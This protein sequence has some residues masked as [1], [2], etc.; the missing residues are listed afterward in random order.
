MDQRGRVFEWD[1]LEYPRHDRSVD[2]Y[3][4]L[5]L[6]SALIAVVA[7]FLDNPLFAVLVITG[8]IAVGILALREAKPITYRVTD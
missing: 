3:W 7:V 2:W 5:G 4:G 8:A 6:T 1:A